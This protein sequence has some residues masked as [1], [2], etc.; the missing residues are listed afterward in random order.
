MGSLYEYDLLQPETYD[1]LSTIQTKTIV[2]VNVHKGGK[3]VFNFLVVY[4]WALWGNTHIFSNLFFFIIF[5]SW[6][7]NAQQNLNGA[8]IGGC[9][10]KRELIKVIK[11]LEMKQQN[12]FLVNVSL[13]FKVQH[14]TTLQHFYTKKNSQKKSMFVKLYDSI[15]LNFFKVFVFRDCLLSPYWQKETI[16]HAN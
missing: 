8:K 14:L 9:N 4:E 6:I 10:L 2:F 13:I 12:R 7:E 11:I 1:W 15:I 5:L 16:F 3:G